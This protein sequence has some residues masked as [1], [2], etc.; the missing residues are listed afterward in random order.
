MHTKSKRT[1]SEQKRKVGAILCVFDTFKTI[2][3][4]DFIIFTGLESSNRMCS[5]AKKKNID[6]CVCFVT[7]RRRNIEQLTRCCCL[8]SFCCIG[9]L[10][11]IYFFTVEHIRLE[12]ASPVKMIKPFRNIVLNVSKTHMNASTMWLTC[13]RLIFLTKIVVSSLRWIRCWWCSVWAKNTMANSHESFELCIGMWKQKTDD[14]LDAVSDTCM[15]VDRFAN[16][17]LSVVQR[18]MS[19]NQ[20]RLSLHDWNGRSKFSD[21]GNWSI[22]Y[23]RLIRMSSVYTYSF[24]RSTRTNSITNTDKSVTQFPVFSRVR[25]HPS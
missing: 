4:I 17:L 9:N 20:C 15:C 23:G 18:M 25:V 16:Q 6:F 14:Y 8:R 12:F 7:I 21:D 19:F 2:F 13:I 24:V 1:N 3:R 11:E 10:H 22:V 5:I